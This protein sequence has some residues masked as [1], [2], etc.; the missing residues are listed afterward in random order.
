M[1]KDSSHIICLSA[2]L[3]D[4]VFSIAKNYYLL[5][6]SEECKCFGKEKEDKQQ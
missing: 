2:I 5:E 3:H 4:S 6:L 1:P